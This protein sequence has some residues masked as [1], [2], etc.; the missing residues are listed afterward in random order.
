MESISEILVM[1]LIGVM[2]SDRAKQVMESLLRGLSSS[3][4]EFAMIDITGVS[5]VDTQVACALIRSAD[6]FLRLR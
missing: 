1:P 4:G 2:D 3:R 6:P 5:V